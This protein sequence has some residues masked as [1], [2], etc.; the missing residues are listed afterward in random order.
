MFLYFFFLLVTQTNV[1]CLTS[2]KY[3]RPGLVLIGHSLLYLSTGCKMITSDC[4]ERQP[5]ER[6][7]LFQM[8]GVSLEAVSY[9]FHLWHQVPRHSPS[10]SAT[11]IFFVSPLAFVCIC[12]EGTVCWPLCLDPERHITPFS[13][14]SIFTT[15]T[16]TRR[17]WQLG[18]LFPCEHSYRSALLKR[19]FKGAD[20]HS[21]TLHLYSLL[22]PH[23]WISS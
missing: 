13:G 12:A 3:V 20:S 22:M 9:L 1:G 2:I 4:G 14:F 7:F 15:G 18:R 23:I 6:A 16:R 19:R 8:L 17:D 21:W 5:G 10:P 11:V